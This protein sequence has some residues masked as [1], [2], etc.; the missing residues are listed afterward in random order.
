MIQKRKLTIIPA[1]VVMTLSLVLSG[2]GEQAAAGGNQDAARDQFLAERGG[3]STPGAASSGT[4]VPGGQPPGVSGIV[5]KV[6]SNQITI[7]NMRDST[8][9]VV[10]VGNTTKIFKQ[11]TALASDIKTGE[12]VNAMGIK[13]GDT[14]IARTVQ[15]GTGSLGVMG[16]GRGAFGNG[17]AFSTPG[18]RPNRTPGI[19]PNGRNGAL[20]SGT[21]PTG[22][23]GQGG[24][25][26]NGA[27]GPN[28]SGTPG[29]PFDFVSGTV[30]KIE[31][32]TY[33]IKT[34]DGTSATFQISGDTRLQK[35]IEAQITDIKE[36]NT[37]SATGQE[38]GDI[39]E[40]TSIQ[41]V[42][43]LAGAAPTSM[44]VP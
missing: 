30:E 2:C 1:L 12:T 26:G 29:V 36:G 9:S 16:A 34:A 35:Q 27:G 4:A 22:F 23:P 11:T 19:V 31:G 24:L 21:P 32:D 39:F 5:A 18:A 37:I 40:A 6:E 44:P 14:I 10:Q 33:T 41:V 28:A 15:I 3:N 7:N 43:G 38:N 25:P 20:P 13:E 8:A 17:S 42:E